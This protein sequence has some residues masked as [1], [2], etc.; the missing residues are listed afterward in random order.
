[1]SVFEV[2]ASSLFVSPAGQRAQ[3][4]NLAKRVLSNALES[5]VA[6][7]YDQAITQ[8]KRT[9]GMSPRSDTAI[10]AH[11]YLARAYLA[12]GD[13]EAALAAY[14]QS[15]KID[16]TRAETHV[17]RGNMLVSLERLDQAAQAYEKAVNLDPSAVN[18]YSLGQAYLEL[19]RHAEAEAQFAR[20]RDIEPG[21][22]N[23]EY[24]L[25][26]AY[27][28]QGRATE[29][30]AAFE[31][32]LALQRDFSLARVELGYVFTDMGET[33]RARE[34]VDALQ[35]QDQ[36]LA[37][38]LSAYI[39]EKTP[40]RMLALP[41]G[42]S[43]PATLGPRT[44]VAA[45]SAYLADANAQQTFSMTFLFSKPMDR[46]S[47]ENIM[48]WSISRSRDTGRGDGYNFGFPLPATEITLAGFPVSVSYDPKTL[49]ATVLFS[50]RQNEHGDGT[51]DPSHIRFAFR[52]V[53]A[54]GLA[55][56][57]RADEYSG[58]SGYA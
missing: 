1:M 11:D 15:V 57:P 8:F 18:R 55:M 6:K 33:D 13:P 14:E 53:D 43:F 19:G 46:S 39:Y 23:G 17:A 36:D 49:S 37:K 10:N 47:V 38:A 20:V 35:S 51:L 7:D 31:R 48:N 58:F 50:V 34:I 56:H 30:I 32:A 29:A 5:F 28:R 9:I 22:P 3:M 25:G 54:T 2:S 24:G 45:L 21:K 42:G 44:Q 16:P 26:L 52:G 40:P 4:D 41:P 27:A 12:K